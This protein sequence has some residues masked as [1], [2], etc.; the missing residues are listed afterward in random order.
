MRRPEDPRKVV[1][2]W[3]L[4][5]RFL[6]AL[7]LQRV[8]EGWSLA[9]VSGD[10]HNAV[11]A[12]RVGQLDVLVFKHTVI[13]PLDDTHAPYPI[14]SS[15]QL[16]AIHLMLRNG[17]GRWT[18]AQRVRVKACWK[19]GSLYAEQEV[20]VP[21]LLPGQCVEKEFITHVHSVEVSAASKQ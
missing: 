2:W 8:P 19:D 11:F 5:R 21:W 20:V 13:V 6:H 14:P 16:P 1:G 3:L 12:S 15:V 18:K 9:R 10:V 7:I 4:L 17:S